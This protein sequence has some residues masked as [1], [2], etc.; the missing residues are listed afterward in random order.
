[1]LP[2]NREVFMPKNVETTTSVW[3]DTIPPQ[4]DHLDGDQTCDVCVIGAG[5]AGLTTAYLLSGS[6]K[7]VFVLEDGEVGGGETRRTTAHLAC[8]LDDR[9]FKVEKTRGKDIARLA[10]ESHAA[11]ISRIE[12]IVSSEGIDC[13]FQ[14]LD[15]FLFV[16]PDRSTRPLKKELEAAHRAGLNDVELVDRAPV[17]SFNT[18]PC[19]RFPR[20]GQFHPMKYLSGLV[21]AIRRN[22]ARLYTGAHVTRVNG[23]NPVRVE[24]KVGHA[25]S[26]AAVVVATNTPITD[27]VSIH[28]KQFPYRTYAIGATISADAVSRALYWDTLDPYHYV[29]LQ[30]DDMLIIGG[31][32]HKTGQEDN[33]GERF[34]RLE[35]WARKRFPIGEVL[36]RWSG[37]VIETMDGLAFIGKDPSGLEN[38]YIITGDSG[39]GMT[40]GTIGGM[41]ISDQIAGRANP[42]IE[43]YDPARK[44]IRGFAEFLKENIN[45]AGQYADWVTGGDVDSVEHIQPGTGAIMR[46]GASKLAVYRADDG[47]IHAMSAACTH[48]GCVVNWNKAEKSWDCP[49]H[50][51]RFDPYGKVVNG[52]AT[53]ELSPADTR[54][55]A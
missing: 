21:D 24:T 8:A 22:G 26:A 9:Y 40:H 27:I 30:N 48:L 44:P 17:E 3:T 52:P 5:I 11:A 7:S 53:K 35:R 15:G 13:D 45:V 42:W 41:L 33:P 36:Y 10:A 55:I 14:R 23:G 54:K 34:R 19:L 2:E 29:R 28:T 25:V 39:M 38:V 6:G 18:G 20:Q 51:S 4:L 47:Q 43:V 16:P 37:Q 31:E 32:D 12:S 1:L 50:G 46:D 49:C